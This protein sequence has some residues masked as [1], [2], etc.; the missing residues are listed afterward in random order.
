MFNRKK[1][2]NEEAA[3]QDSLGSEEEPLFGGAAVD[4]HSGEASNGEADEETF[5]EPAAATEAGAHTQAESEQTSDDLGDSLSSGADAPVPSDSAAASGEGE[6]ETTG[7]FAAPRSFAVRTNNA[8]MGSEARRAV[9]GVPFDADGAFAHD[10]DIEEFGSGD[11]DTFLDDEQ[12]DYYRY[13]DAMHGVRQT[14]ED[15]R[16]RDDQ[17]V[18]LDESGEPVAGG[19]PGPQGPR[20]GKHR[21]P[22]KK[23]QLEAAPEHVRKSHRT[24]HILIVVVIA[25][26]AVLIAIGVWAVSLY[27]VNADTAVQQV[28]NT[29]SDVDAVS[30]DS[31][32]TSDSSTENVKVTEVPLLVSLMGLTQDEAIAT[33][34]HGATATVATPIAEEGNPVSTSVTVLLTDEPADSKSGTPTVYLGLNADGA[35]IQ[36]GYSAATASLGYGNLSFGDAIT[37]EHVVENTLDDA[38]LNVEA[39]TVE[40]PSDKMSYTSYASD[41][42]TVTSERCSFDGS[43][44]VNGANYTWSAVLSY[45]YTAANASGNLADTVRLITVYINAA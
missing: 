9:S 22:T 12:R 24:R 45:D 19:A 21:K 32:T 7:S 35:V 16:Y 14:A 3:L 36:A 37:N 25:L 20:R 30:S 27:R 34:G 11:S 23:E 29:S 10:A 18:E 26:I 4:N 2:R 38:G 13:G 43:C 15:D 31:D 5:S 41:G 28:D 42:K 6:D 40:L 33:L 39:G 1:K 17:N 8:P 44:T